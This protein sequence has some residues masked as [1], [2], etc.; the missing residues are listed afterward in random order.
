MST[1]S[2]KQAVTTGSTWSELL[3]AM[4]SKSGSAAKT[5]SRPW[6]KTRWSSTMTRFA[7][8]SR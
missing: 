1:A 2:G 3:M 8:I 7:L 5:A 4:G 6:Q